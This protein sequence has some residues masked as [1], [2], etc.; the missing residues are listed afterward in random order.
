MQK[1]DYSKVFHG[2]TIP[3]IN[4]GSVSYAQHIEKHKT[5]IA[6]ARILQQQAEEHP[7]YTNRDIGYKPLQVFQ[8]RQ[9]R[10]SSE[11]ANDRID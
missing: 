1:K 2:L 3:I 8:T 10:F 7:D 9:N 11:K 5:G 4:P 6:L